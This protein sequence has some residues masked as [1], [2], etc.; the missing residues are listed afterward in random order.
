MMIAQ[1]PVDIATRHTA[2]FVAANLRA[3]DRAL[4]VGCGNGHLAAELAQRGFAVTGVDADRECVAH[5]RILGIEAIQC[6]WPDCAIRNGAFDVIAF[7][8]SLHHF[9]RLQESIVAAKRRIRPGGLLLLEDFSH[10]EIDAAA[11]DWL[12]GVLR[13]H[14]AT[15]APASSGL[16]AAL[17]SAT[18]WPA[19]WRRYHTHDHQLHPVAAMRDAI[20]A[21]FAIRNEAR[22]PY[23]YR[24]LIPLLPQS[25]DAAALLDEI[26]TD[27]LRAAAQD[28]FVPVG[29]RLVAVR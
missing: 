15:L 4:E 26:F 6:E 5:A 10:D 7:T 8:R 12:A 2:D 29:W 3:G 24:Y 13:A 14:A 23:L 18:D 21:E 27:E 11:L 16:I 17:Q 1:R 20:A 22:V 25:P 19:A 28:R 9:D